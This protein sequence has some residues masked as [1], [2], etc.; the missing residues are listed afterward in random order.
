VGNSVSFVYRIL[1]GG[2]DNRAARKNLQILVRDVESSFADILRLRGGS[3][4][5]N[6]N[7]KR[8]PGF[9]YASLTVQFEEIRFLIIRGRRELR[10]CVAS[11]KNPEDWQEMSAFLYGV[12]SQARSVPA[13]DF[14]TV[15]TPYALYRI[16]SSLKAHWDPIIATVRQ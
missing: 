4:I 5:Y 11:P 2:L 13:T 3:L 16:A 1:F 9:D 12:D 14:D 10:I 8:T 6:D 7:W 15:D